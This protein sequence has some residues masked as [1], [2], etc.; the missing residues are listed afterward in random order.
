M[1][2]S[3]HTINRNMNILQKKQENTSANIANVKTPGYKFQ[4]IIQST[5]ESKE[6]LNYSG[7]NKSNRRQE[8][9]GFT[10]GNQIDEVYRNF[11][12]GSLVDTGNS[13]DFAIV[14]NG[15]FTI[16]M[17][18]GQVGFTRNGNF[19]LN[20]ENQLV[21]IDGYQ[22]LGVDA[23]GQQNYIYLDNDEISTTN[24]L[25][26]DFPDYGNLTSAGNTIFTSDAG[27]NKAI[28]GEISQDYLEMSNVVIADELVRMIE[29]SR[30]FEANQKLLHTADETLNKA[31]NEI[32][33]V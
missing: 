1:I 12:Q 4:D 18:N 21:T 27:D 28:T 5:L 11:E 10:F 2:K 25:I 6:M 16:Q 23:N 24:F 8:L 32:G 22:V 3:I 15:F 17:G 19:K 26:S 29:I 20:E 33:R 14:G 7:G 9:G 31:V 13:K 30:E